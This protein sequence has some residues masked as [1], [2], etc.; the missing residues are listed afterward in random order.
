MCRSKWGYCGTGEAYCGDGCTA[1]PFFGGNSGGN[2]N[3][4]ING[5]GSI[6]TEQNFACAFNTIDAGTRLNRLIDLRNSGWKPSNK[7]E[8]AVFLAHVFHETDGLKTIREYCAP[9]KTEYQLGCGSGYAG[10]WCSIQGV[11]DKLYYGRGWFQLS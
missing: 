3:N 8:A 9:D 11:S 4:V 5:D 1:K 2:E 6:T 10:S 7:E